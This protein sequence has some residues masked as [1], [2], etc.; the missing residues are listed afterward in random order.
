MYGTT[1]E[2]VQRYNNNT[3]T[4]QHIL[5][6]QV[7]EKIV[8]FFICF[9]LLHVISVISISENYIYNVLSVKSYTM[10]QG[11]KHTDIGTI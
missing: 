7:K 3:H 11:H 1:Q 9:R 10:L 4:I 2:L 5:F 6:R 8:L